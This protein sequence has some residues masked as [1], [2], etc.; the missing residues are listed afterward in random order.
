MSGFG[1]PGPRTQWS[2]VSSS[3]PDRSSTSLMRA[4]T[5]HGRRRSLSISPS[6]HSS[7][8]DAGPDAWGQRVIL[9]HRVGRDAMDTADLGTLTYLLD[10]GSDR[11]ILVG[12]SDDHARNHAAFWDGAELT[13]TPAFDIC[14]QPRGGGETS[15]ATIEADGYR[16]RSQWKEVCDL[17]EML[18]VDREGFWRRQFLN[19]YALEGY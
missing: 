11:D 1:F 7:G 14:P 18:K 6:Y 12:N 13:L 3:R 8:P 10:S 16:I 2:G 19:E 4:A 5:W 17:A 15:Q 9:N